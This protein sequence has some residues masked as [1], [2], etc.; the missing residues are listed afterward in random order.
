[1]V[2]LIALAVE[3]VEHGGGVGGVDESGVLL[4]VAP[5]AAVGERAARGGADRAGQAREAGG[6]EDRAV[7][8]EVVRVGVGALDAPIGGVLEDDGGARRRG[9]REDGDFHGPVEEEVGQAKLLG[10]L[11]VELVRRETVRVRLGADGLRAAVLARV[12]AG[13]I[14]EPGGRVGAA[15]HGHHE[16]IE[17]AAGRALLELRVDRVVVQVAEPSA[18]V[19]PVV[20]DLRDLAPPVGLQDGGEAAGAV[21]WAGEEVEEAERSRRRRV[22]VRGRVASADVVLSRVRSERMS[23]RERWRFR[24]GQQR[25]AGVLA[26]PWEV[27]LIDEDRRGGDHAAELGHPNVEGADGG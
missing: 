26:E 10:V 13:G 24:R 16:G 5:E 7:V 14:E 1:M 9:P 27:L 17:L 11:R 23:G 18:A 22:D 6:A 19:L 4:R 21:V 12:A 15:V 20:V 8:R 2:A 3:Q 25:L